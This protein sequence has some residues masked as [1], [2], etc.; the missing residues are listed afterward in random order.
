LNL[1][2]NKPLL[3]RIVKTTDI[4]VFLKCDEMTTEELL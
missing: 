1:E 2:E 4:D 3:K